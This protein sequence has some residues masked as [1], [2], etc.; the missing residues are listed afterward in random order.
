MPT[1]ISTN[2]Q[3]KTIDKTSSTTPCQTLILQI[4][5]CSRWL[6]SNDFASLVLWL[7]CSYAVTVSRHFILGWPHGTRRSVFVQCNY[8]LNM[9]FITVNNPLA[10]FRPLYSIWCNDDVIAS[11]VCVIFSMPPSIAGVTGTITSYAP[12]AYRRRSGE[13]RLNKYSCTSGLLRFARS[14]H[15]DL[16]WWR[17]DRFYI[18]FSSYGRVV[19]QSTWRTL[20]KLNYLLFCKQKLTNHGW[21]RWKKESMKARWRA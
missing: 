7:Q 5:D 3:M 13:P 6:T 16:R 14:K 4:N 20:N 9:K 1:S 10:T 21:F 17:S 11:R 2:S 15:T 18:F 8:N 19:R 12:L